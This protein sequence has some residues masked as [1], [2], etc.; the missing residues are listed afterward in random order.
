MHTEQHSSHMIFSR[1]NKDA[2]HFIDPSN[3]DLGTF[4]P[5][6]QPPPHSV[7]C[8]IDMAFPV[9]EQPTLQPI[10]ADNDPHHMIDLMYYPF[11]QEDIGRYWQNCTRSVC[12]AK[13]GNL[14]RNWG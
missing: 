2:S 8:L 12:K 7:H 4:L 3:K 11:N 10:L 1:V 14:L 6:V 9:V 5:D 13:A